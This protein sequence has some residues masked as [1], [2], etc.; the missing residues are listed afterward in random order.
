MAEE[1]HQV[2]APGTLIQV[3]A[4]VEG[5]LETGKCVMKIPGNTIGGSLGIRVDEKTVLC[6][7][8]LSHLP[9]IFKF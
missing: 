9:F 7:V 6:I 4:L 3:A 2:V 5:D 8:Y 1:E